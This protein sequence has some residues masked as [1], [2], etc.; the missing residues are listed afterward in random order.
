MQSD[1][2]AFQFSLHFVPFFPLSYHNALAKLSSAYHAMELHHKKND[3]YQFRKKEEYMP[4]LLEIHSSWLRL[5]D[6]LRHAQMT[7]GTSHQRCQ[8]PLSPK[9]GKDT[10]V[11]PSAS[12]RSADEGRST[13]FL[14]VLTAMLVAMHARIVS[15]TSS[16]H[17]AVSVSAPGNI[18]FI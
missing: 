11:D 18:G 8:L 2:G 10:F 12:A 4:D 16:A 3:I 17:C 7:L 6:L 14:S 13:F 5:K 15:L 1:L 9:A